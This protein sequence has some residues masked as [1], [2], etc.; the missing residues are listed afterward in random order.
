MAMSFASVPRVMHG[1]LLNTGVVFSKLARGAVEVVRRRN[2]M[3]GVLNLVSVPPQCSVL[4]HVQKSGGH[5]IKL[6]L[7]PCRN[8][9]V[10]AI[11]GTVEVAADQI[12]FVL[13]DIIEGVM[14]HALQLVQVHSGSRR[15]NLTQF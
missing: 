5:R 2:V 11:V 3:Y 9:P 8:V 6:E 15:T 14:V 10:K 4:I 1:I 13:L 12:A 7:K